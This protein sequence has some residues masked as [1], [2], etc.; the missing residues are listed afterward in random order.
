MAS[1]STFDLVKAAEALLENAKKLAAV[2]TPGNDNNELA[3]RRTIAKTANR[4]AFETAPKIDVVKADWIVLA[5]VAAWNIFIEW[6]AFDHIPLGGHISIADLARILNAQE[7]LVARISTQLLSTHKL[8]PG[9]SRDTLSHSR[10]SPLYRTTHPVSPLCTVAVGNAMKPF[11][12]WPAFFAAHGRREPPGQTH[13]PFSFGWG[14]AELPPWEVKAL[15]P[16]YASAFARSMR[17]RQIVGGNT[18]VTG[19]GALY[20]LSWVGEEA[21]KMEEGRAVVV[22]VGGG[23]GQLVREVVRDVEGVR[24]G[25]CV[26]QDRGEVIEEARGVARV[27]GGLE[28]VVMMEH[29]FHEEQPVKGALVYLLRRILLDYSDT[30]AT[31]ILRRLAEALPTDNPRARVIIMEERLLEVPTPQNSVVDMVML[32]LGGKLRNEAMFRDIARAAGLRLVG[33]YTRAEDSMSVV[34]CARA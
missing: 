7:S 32:N 22:D 23:L 1:P 11:A 3:L 15:Y 25:Q 30:L 13:T 20:D 31:G 29:D 19:E 34:E 8:L 24:G 5:D 28:G 6:Q 18:P 21:E 9:P 27:E 2:T 17:S 10:I 33:Y 16:E 4:I 14:H 26:L 12:H